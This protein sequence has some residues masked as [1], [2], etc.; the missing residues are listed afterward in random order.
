MALFNTSKL[1]SI[2]RPF[3]D[4]GI[5]HQHATRFARNKSSQLENT[6]AKLKNPK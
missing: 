4:D 1:L 3:A 2:G 6:T 5:D